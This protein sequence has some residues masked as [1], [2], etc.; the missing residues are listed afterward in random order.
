MKFEV[1]TAAIVIV[2]VITLLIRNTCKS[3]THLGFEKAITMFSFNLLDS[4][5][6]MIMVCTISIV[7]PLVMLFILFGDIYASV[8]TSSE[9]FQKVINR[10]LFF[11]YLTFCGIYVSNILQD[12]FFLETVKT[13]AN[14]SEWN[15]YILHFILTPVLFLDAIYSIE[16]EK[17]K[18]ENYE[19]KLRYNPVLYILAQTFFCLYLLYSLLIILFLDSQLSELINSLIS[20]KV[21]GNALIISGSLL[22][23]ISE[24]LLCVFVSLVLGLI[25]QR[26]ALSHFLSLFR[27]H[28]NWVE[29]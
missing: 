10:H 12:Y 18:Y 26:V 13:L 4:N 24:A 16:I 17:I 14:Y 6:S 7:I 20:F 22:Q 5:N 8:L 2:T 29:D 23:L 25:D 1:K 21:G 3:K 27:V 19:K 9:F 15:K 11:C 28:T